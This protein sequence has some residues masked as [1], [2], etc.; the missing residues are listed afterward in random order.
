MFLYSNKGG[1]PILEER[2]MFFIKAYFNAFQIY[3]H[4]VIIHIITVGDS[5]DNNIL[6][7]TLGGVI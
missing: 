5:S 3:F 2:C 7:V 4:N 1:R 6:I